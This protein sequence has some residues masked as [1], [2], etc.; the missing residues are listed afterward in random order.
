MSECEYVPV[1]RFNDYV[2]HHSRE[3]ELMEKARSEA[4]VSIDLRLDA[5][6]HLRREL[7]RDR[8][9]FVTRPSSE[10]EF[11]ASAEK[12]DIRHTNLEGRLRQVETKIA[13]RNSSTATWVISVG[14]IMIFVQI[15]VAMVLRFLA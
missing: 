14:V 2:A 6:N 1:Q 3:H 13:E 4:K 12:A 11:R 7:E 10:A 5:L 9:M 15:A 8:G